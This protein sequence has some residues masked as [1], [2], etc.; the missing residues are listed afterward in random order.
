M[1]KNILPLSIIG[2]KNSQRQKTVIISVV[3]RISA[4]PCCMSTSSYV[5]TFHW[6]FC[7]GVAEKAPCDASWVINTACKK[8]PSDL[9]LNLSVDT[10]ATHSPKTTKVE[11][12]ARAPLFV[13]ILC[14]SFLN[15]NVFDMYGVQ[16]P[17]VSV[18]L[19]PKAPLNAYIWDESLKH[20]IQYSTS[21]SYLYRSNF[22]VWICRNTCE[23]EG[24]RHS[25]PWNRWWLV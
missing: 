14:V 6:G 23:I 11:W 13:W 22:S 25:S 4:C 18:P 3:R 19:T 10:N 5:Q 17:V 2:F 16:T 12:I 15:I 21:I 20:A 1:L 7:F 8:R 24:M 9:R